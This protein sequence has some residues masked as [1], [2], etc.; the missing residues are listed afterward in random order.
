MVDVGYMYLILPSFITLPTFFHFPLYIPTAIFM[1]LMLTQS[2]Y[3]PYATPRL[4]INLGF[5]FP[6]SCCYWDCS[7]AFWLSV[8]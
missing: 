4:R 1:R 2:E 7:Q 6:C 5:I 3:P 8:N